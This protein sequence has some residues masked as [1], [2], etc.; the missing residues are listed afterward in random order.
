M[1]DA[2][3][4][5]GRDRIQTQPVLLKTQTSQFSNFYL[6][7]HSQRLRTLVQLY[8]GGLVCERGA[9]DGVLGPCSARPPWG[10]CVVLVCLTLFASPLSTE[11]A[12]DS[13]LG[14]LW[15]GCPPR[16]LCWYVPRMF[17]FT[18]TVQARLL[19]MGWEYQPGQRVLLGCMQVVS[20]CLLWELGLICYLHAVCTGHVLNVFCF[21]VR[22]VD[23][24]RG[25]GRFCPFLLS[26][27]M[28]CFRRML[29]WTTVEF[30]FCLL[31]FS[32]I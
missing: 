30:L 11:S 27:R 15:P 9:G 7:S 31:N 3:P 2:E 19:W 10:S 18:P 25:I 21:L 32:H 17:R 24:K 28:L 23:G 4:V 16:P 22:K 26:L 29:Y 1:K 5:R 20:P 6:E 14:S 8:C 13:A 12:I